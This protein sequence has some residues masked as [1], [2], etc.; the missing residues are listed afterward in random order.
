MIILDVSWPQRAAYGPCFVKLSLPRHP[1]HT[2]TVPV[3]LTAEERQGE[4]ETSMTTRMPEAR[5]HSDKR[6]EQR[7]VGPRGRGSPRGLLPG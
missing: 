5:L 6:S 4:H 2:E 7:L 3:E 1:P